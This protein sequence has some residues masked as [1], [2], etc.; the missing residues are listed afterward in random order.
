MPD[1]SISVKAVLRQCIQDVM[2][3]LLKNECLLYEGS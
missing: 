1:C 2:Y 3:S